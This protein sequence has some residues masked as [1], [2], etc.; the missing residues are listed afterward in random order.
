MDNQEEMEYPSISIN[1]LPSVCYM[2]NGKNSKCQVILVV[3]AFVKLAAYLQSVLT[4]LGITE[5]GYST[6]QLNLES[7]WISSKWK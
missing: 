4:L 3:S 6:W 1:N 7:N 2:T 5:F